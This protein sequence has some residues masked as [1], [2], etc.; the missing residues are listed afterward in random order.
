MSRNPTTRIVARCIVAVGI[1][2]SMLLAGGAPTD[3]SKA[4]KVT[5]VS[6]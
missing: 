6:P 5:L 1:L 3:F 2:L 4:P